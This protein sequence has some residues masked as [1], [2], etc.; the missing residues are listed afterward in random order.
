AALAT[1]PPA[2]SEVRNSRTYGVL[3]LTLR[4]GSYDWQFVPEAGKTFTDSGSH[5]C[6]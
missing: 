2:N 5:N 3:K 1:T 6:H 4:A